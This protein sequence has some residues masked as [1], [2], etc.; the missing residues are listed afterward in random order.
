MIR[1]VRR[2]EV[3]T[4]IDAGRTI[5]V[6]ALPPEYFRKGHLPG[7]LNIPVDEVD[8]LARTL[9]PNRSA[10]IIVYC[11]NS[12]C[13]NS[14]TV[15]RRLSAMGYTNILDYDEGK[16]DWIDAGLPTEPGD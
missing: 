12:A 6:E 15:A 4:R 10:E 3:R 8:S 1:M 5:V 7:A 14:A 16:D 13:R 2:D 9:L 11:A